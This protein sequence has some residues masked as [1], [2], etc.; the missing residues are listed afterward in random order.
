MSLR[1]SEIL[2]LA[3]EDLNRMRTEFHD[4]YSKLFDDSTI[5]MRK[6]L[7]LKIK[8]EQIC[9]E[10]EEAMSEAGDSR[11]VSEFE[12]NEADDISKNL[13][14]NFEE[15]R[16]VKKEEI[17]YGLQAADLGKIDEVSVE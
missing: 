5:R 8:A 11:S 6:T 14:L 7:L 16:S 2:C 13:N 4:Q 9:Q 15:I 3:I 17:D 1:D 12:I 10:K